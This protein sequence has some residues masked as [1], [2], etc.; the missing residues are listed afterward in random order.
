LP[1][2]N[3]RRRSGIRAVVWDF[4]THVFPRSIIEAMAGERNPADR[5]VFG[6]HGVAL[7]SL[8]ERT[9]GIVALA[10]QLVEVMLKI[11]GYVMLVAPFAVFAAL[12]SIIAQNGLGILLTY[13]KFILSFYF[14]LLV[15]WVVIAAF[16]SLVIG[17]RV[18]AAGADQ[19]GVHAVVRDRQLRGGLSQDP[20]RARPFRGEAQDLQLRDADGLLV[21]PGRFDDVLH[22]CH[23]VHRA[24]LQRRAVPGSS[25]S[26]CR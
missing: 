11:T 12:A 15:L 18:V 5:R 3:A 23:V 24:G 8:G 16:G 21:Q 17:R 20:G 14:A 22:L 9:A 2:E 26:R 19:G 1:P 10:E 7:A 13:S 4:V 6:I 25:R